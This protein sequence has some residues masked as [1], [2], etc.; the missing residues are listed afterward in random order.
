M[1]IFSNSL[2]RFLIP[3]IILLVAL[4]ILV[5]IQNSLFQPPNTVNVVG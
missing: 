3:I 2:M 5:L 4:T 1:D